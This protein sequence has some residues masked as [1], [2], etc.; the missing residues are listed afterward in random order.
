MLCLFVWVPR[1]FSKVCKYDRLHRLSFAG[2]NF[3]NLMFNY[4]YKNDN[5]VM[6]NN[7]LNIVNLF[8]LQSACLQ[9]K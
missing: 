4:W 2:T 1:Y 5:Q 7:V 3:I 9:L 6:I 8:H